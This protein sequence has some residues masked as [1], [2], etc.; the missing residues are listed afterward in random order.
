MKNIITEVKTF[1]EGLDRQLEVAEERT[2]KHEDGSFE[3]VQ[4]KGQKEKKSISEI[5]GNLPH[6]PRNTLPV[7]GQRAGVWHAFRALSPI[8]SL[9]FTARSSN[10][11]DAI[12]ASC[13]IKW[14]SFS[15]RIFK[16][17]LWMWLT[18]EK[19]AERTFENTMA[20]TSH[21]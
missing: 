7:E 4:S 18:R 3:I 10:R 2:R 14:F 11:A 15:E 17:L 21:I 5:C 16:C 1:L 9:T 13:H 8:Y 20:I 12:L 6:I 19:K